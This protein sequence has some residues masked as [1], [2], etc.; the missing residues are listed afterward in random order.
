MPAGAMTRRWTP[1][2]HYWLLRNRASVMI[3]FDLVVERLQNLACVYVCTITC[4]VLN[5]KK[6]PNCLCK[7]ASCSLINDLVD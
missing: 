5:E 4:R 3:R 1:S 6:E 2:T 7:V